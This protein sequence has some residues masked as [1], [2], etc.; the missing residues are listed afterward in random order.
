[1][2]QAWLAAIVD[3]PLADDGLCLSALAPQDMLDELQFYLPIDNL[4]QAEDVDRITH[5]YDPLSAACPP[6]NFE[7]VQGILKGFIDLTFLWKGKFYLLDYKSNYLG[8]DAASYTQSAM[9]E[10]MIDHRYDLQYQL[11]SLALHRYLKQRLPNYQYDVH[12]GGVYYLFLRGIDRVESK[13]GIFIIG[14]KRH[15]STNWTDYFVTHKR[16]VSHDESAV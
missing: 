1:M 13:N 5:R 7:K 11:Y 8:D 14:Q 16:E 4:L 12:F 9:A 2:L 6:L 3:A 10:A 15:L